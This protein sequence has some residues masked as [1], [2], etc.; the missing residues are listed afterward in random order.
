MYQKR[1]CLWGFFNKPKPEITEYKT[2]KFDKLHVRDLPQ[3]PDD[4]KLPKEY[5]G[6]HRAA[7]RAI[8]PQGFANA[9]YK[10]NK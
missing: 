7:M 3:L 8:T 6:N 5:I 2:T 4:Y 10:A 1:T 9:F